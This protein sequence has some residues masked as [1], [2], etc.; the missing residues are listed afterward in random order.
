MTELDSGSASD[1]EVVIIEDSEDDSISNYPDAQPHEPIEAFSS[2]TDP[3]ETQELFSEPPG[4]DD[5][6]V[7]P[8]TPPPAPRDDAS[9][10]ED[11]TPQWIHRVPI[12]SGSAPADAPAAKRARLGPE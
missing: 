9:E 7:V 6:A 8:E 3:D 4:D 1:S 2:D 11:N 10:D 5:V 12:R